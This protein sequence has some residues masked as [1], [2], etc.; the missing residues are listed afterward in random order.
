MI[1]LPEEPG[2]GVMVSVGVTVI[3]NPTLTLAR[4]TRRHTRKD[5]DL[6]GIVDNA[7]HSATL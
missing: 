6:R 7:W 3:A 2:F 4:K 5:R 1:G